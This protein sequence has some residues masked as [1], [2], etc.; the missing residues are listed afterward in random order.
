MV[1]NWP[2]CHRYQLT[3]IIVTHSNI[4]T[5][6]MS[7]CTSQQM[8]FI[9]IYIDAD[10]NGFCSAHSF[11]YSNTCFTTSKRLAAKLKW[12][13]FGRSFETLLTYYIDTDI[14]QRNRTAIADWIYCHFIIRVEFNWRFFLCRYSNRWCLLSVLPKKIENNFFRSLINFLRWELPLEMQTTTEIIRW[15]VNWIWCFHCES[16]F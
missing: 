7:H 1:L 5:N 2:K 13:K 14:R 8:W 3:S 16:E 9:H 12:I 15:Q 10:A 6:H 4:V 11:R